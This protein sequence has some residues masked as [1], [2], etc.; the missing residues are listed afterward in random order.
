M[1]LLLLY[2]HSS[3]VC[4]LYELELPGL[5]YVRPILRTVISILRHILLA[6][7]LTNEIVKS[8]Y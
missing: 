4:L 5:R 1:S 8:I 3:S 2:G 6:P 7:F